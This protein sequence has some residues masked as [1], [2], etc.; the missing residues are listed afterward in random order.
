VLM[1]RLIHYVLSR[2]TGAIHD[3]RDRTPLSF[4]TV[5]Q[6]RLLQVVPDGDNNIVES[7]SLPISKWE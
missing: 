6:L 5:Y 2:L 1:F 4:E 3:L 7:K